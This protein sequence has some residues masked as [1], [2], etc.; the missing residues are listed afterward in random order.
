MFQWN[1]KFDSSKEIDAA[2][3]GQLG[4]FIGGIV[5]SL[6]ALLGVIFFYVALTEQR[7][8]FKT[9][10]EAFEKQ[11]EAFDEQSKQLKFQNEELIKTRA[12]YEEQNKTQKIQQFESNFYSILQVFLEIQRNI[13]N[14]DS[15]FF[16]SIFEEIIKTDDLDLFQKFK[17]RIDNYENIYTEKNYLSQYFKTFYRILKMIDSNT[18]IPNTKEKIM[19]SKIL[20]SQ[21]SEYEV[22]VMMFNSYSFYGAKSKQLILK[23]NILKNKQNF[24]LPEFSKFVPEINKNKLIVFSNNL[25]QFISENLPKLT[26]ITDESLFEIEE[27]SFDTILSLKSTDNFI[28]SVIFK[29]NGYDNTGF[30]KELFNDFFE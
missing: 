16:K 7:Q 11:I 18:Q 14:E 23:Y 15:K 21:L 20:R 22:L 4:D 25:K 5:G 9:N 8:D 30:D 2:K 27:K 24:L 28:I 1:L 13:H 10:K 19:Y 6:W 3:I 17:I 29:P 26:S 12:I